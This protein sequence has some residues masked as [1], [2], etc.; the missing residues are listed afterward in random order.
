MVGRSGPPTGSVPLT[1]TQCG[2]SSSS[3]SFGNMQEHLELE[4]VRA[5]ARVFAVA[6]QR[7]E[8]PNT[9]ALLPPDVVRIALWQC[10]VLVPTKPPEGWGAF[11]DPL[12]LFVEEE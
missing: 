9:G 7:G 10:E 4:I 5:V 3:S 2:N 8:R 6:A 1:S 11:L 12:V